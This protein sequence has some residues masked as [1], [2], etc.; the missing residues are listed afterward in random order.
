MQHLRE[1]EI[2]ILQA[3]A[4]AYFEREKRARRD[5]EESL[6]NLIDSRCSA[7]K[8][9]I[10]QESSLRFESVDFIESALGSDVPSL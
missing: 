9:L 10:S 8:K 4:D 2:S 5:Q 3:E 6:I 7:L 1:S